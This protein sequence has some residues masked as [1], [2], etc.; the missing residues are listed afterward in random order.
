MADPF[1]PSGVAKA[2]VMLPPAGA[3]LKLLVETMVRKGHTREEIAE[4][5]SSAD[6]SQ[7]SLG[8]TPRRITSIVA[9]IADLAA[10][11][12][13]AGTPIVL[14]KNFNY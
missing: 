3:K 13:D 6:C 14:V 4:M 5:L 8:T 9:T 10:G 7:N 12:A 11:S 2:C 1:P